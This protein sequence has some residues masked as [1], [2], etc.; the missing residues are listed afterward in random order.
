MSLIVLYLILRINKK[1]FCIFMFITI[2]SVLVFKNIS[3]FI[4]YYALLKFKWEKFTG[5]V[6]HHL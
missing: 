4:E 2:Q 1:Y 5:T 6:L 3:W